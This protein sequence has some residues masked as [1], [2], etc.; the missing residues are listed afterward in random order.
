MVV[1]VLLYL[2][3]FV[4]GLIIGIL[5][6]E[7]QPKHPTFITLKKEN[8]NVVTIKAQTEVDTKFLV[9]P[10]AEE[11]IKR[12]ERELE[13]ELLYQLRPHVEYRVY[14]DEFRDKRVFKCGVRV[15]QESGKDERD[16]GE[17]HHFQL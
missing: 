1:N 6:G 14:T 10:I 15:L 9:E 13:T 16:E 5:L 2:M 11:V 17:R 4:Y 8:V 3:L 12:C 7:Q